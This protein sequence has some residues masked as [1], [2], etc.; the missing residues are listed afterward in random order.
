MPGPGTA[1][2]LTPVYLFS[3]NM[4]LIFPL[5]F[6]TY[7]IQIYDQK[8]KDTALCFIKIVFFLNSIY[9]TKK[10]S[11]RIQNSKTCL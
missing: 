8:F 11:N 5:T 4:I 1:L 7:Q 2:N 3:N 6:S 9:S 10:S